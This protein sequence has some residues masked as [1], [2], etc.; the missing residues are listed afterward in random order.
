M[1]EQSFA[2]NSTVLVLLAPGLQT[3]QV[4]LL[5]PRLLHS[6]AGLQVFV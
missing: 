2:I 3:L 4:W 5:A 1:G 6:G